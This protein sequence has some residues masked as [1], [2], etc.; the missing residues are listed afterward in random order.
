MP[1]PILPDFETLLSSLSVV[2]PADTSGFQRAT[3]IPSSVALDRG[4]TVAVPE[5]GI[6]YRP[7]GQFSL[8]SLVSRLEKELANNKHPVTRPIV[9]SFLALFSLLRSPSEQVVPSLNMFI[10]RIVESQVF[11]TYLFPLTPTPP[12][13]LHLPRFHFQL[14]D[15][16][17]LR[18]RCEKA[19]SDYYTRYRSILSS[20]L[21]IERDPFSVKVVDWFQDIDEAVVRL[22]RDN[23]LREAYPAFFYFYF[24]QIGLELA[25]HFWSSMLEDQHILI[26]AG[27]PYINERNLSQLLGSEIVTIFLGIGARKSGFVFPASVGC[28]YVELGKTD[29]RIPAVATKLATEFGFTGFSSHEVHQTL[30]TFSTF[31]SKAERH[32]LDGR[33]D[34]G[35]LHFVIA[36]DLVFG[37]AI[38]G[39][40]GMSLARS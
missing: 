37:V 40:S 29:V 14:L 24:E 1:L 9:L 26:A 28:Q 5:R 11:Q 13:S 16:G 30:R 39:G 8:D 20:R 12:F 6:W 18:D 35:F 17:Q 38:H 27:A 33:I 4:R 36:L 3:V 2:Q 15:E 32:Y 34:E 31:V 10:E 22:M 19:Q 23:V 21:S 25:K 7:A